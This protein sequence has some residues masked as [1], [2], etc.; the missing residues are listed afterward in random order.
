[1]S[2]EEKTTETT[3]EK[4]ATKEA[5]QK[6][7]DAITLAMNESGVMAVRG[8][9]V[10]MQAVRM[11]YG[12]RMLKATLTEEVIRK[13]FLPMMGSP[14]GF[15]T[16]RDSGTNGPA[17]TW[18]VVRDVVCEAVLRGFYPVNNEFNIIAGRFYGAKNGFER[19]V[20]EWPGLRDLSIDMGVPVLVADKGALVPCAARW[21]LDGEQM[22]IHCVE[23]GESGFDTRIPVT[24][25][26]KM[27]N[28]AILGKA[29]RKLHARV[30]QRLSGCARD[31]VEGD[32]EV[33]PVEHLP[34]LA[35]P[36]KDGQRIKM[37]GN[38]RGEKTHAPPAS[39]TNGND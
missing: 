1:M 19:V 3:I 31:V 17:Y 39:D 12:M 2:T 33:I 35:A 29:M 38:S 10:F 8:E 16:D 26:S 20:R 25:N 27:G 37:G 24:V 32:A 4:P 13:N 22:A 28:D 9:P 5:M 21:M 11:S 30:Y 23:R 14:L 6:I 7:S 36:E 15:V 18:E 34:A